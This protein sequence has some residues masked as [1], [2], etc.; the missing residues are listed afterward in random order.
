MEDIDGIDEEKL[1]DYQRRTYEVAEKLIQAF[2]WHD[3]PPGFDYWHDVYDNLIKH[4]KDDVD[5]ELEKKHTNSNNND[6][7][8]KELVMNL[9]GDLFA[10]FTWEDTEE[11]HKYWAD[12]CHRLRRIA[13]EGF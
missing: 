10:A 11:G 13:E 2:T 4:V 7:H 6:P 1:N 5:A 3:V 12:I 9:A 8:T